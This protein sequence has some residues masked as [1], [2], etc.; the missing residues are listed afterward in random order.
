MKPA[1]VLAA[2]AALH[3]FTLD[4]VAAYC[5]G[6]ERDVQEV[7]EGFGRYF[8]PVGPRSE[9]SRWRV[10]DPAAL[11]AAIVRAP[12]G[13]AQART[14]QPQGAEQ[15]GSL[16]ARLLLAEETL[17]ECGREPEP[18]YRRIMA[19]TVMNYLQQVVAASSPGRPDWWAV[20]A[21]GL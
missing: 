7:I 15:R 10:S 16:E 8:E 3:E 19:S 20:Q 21:A 2:A 6:D 11:R 18:A 1:D 17:V 13:R 9:H 12:A 14:P 4:Q 5:E